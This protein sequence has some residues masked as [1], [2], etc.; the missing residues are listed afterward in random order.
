MKKLKDK[1]HILPDMER[2]I[3]VTGVNGFVGSNLL[4]RLMMERRFHLVALDIKK[5]DFLKKEAVKFYKIDLTQPNVD[6][7]ILSVVKREAVDTFIHL[8]FLSSPAP[9]TAYAHEM[10]VIGTMSVLHA[11]AEG[12]VRKLIVGSTTMVYGA[13]PMNPNFLDENAP[14]NGAGGYH[15]VRDKVEV[16]QL[17]GKFRKRYPDRIV[18]VLRPC[19]IVGP[20]VQNYATRLLRL[21]VVTTVLGY[22]PLFQF[23]HEEDV[24]DAFLLAV[25][26]D[27]SGEY[28]VVGRGV[29]PISTL[30]KL[31][32]KIAV[33]VAHFVAA[34]I[35]DVLW[36]ANLSPIP[37]AHLNY[38]RYL[39]VVDGEKAKKELGF[40]PRYSTKEA[41][42]NFVGTQ[43]LKDLHLLK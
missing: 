29:L 4:S 3:A 18:T 36:G 42:E 11:C 39:W 20:T 26:K 40:T 35:L 38:L 19:T 9:T 14:L 6:E 34:P 15:F 41:L 31:A 32:G 23:I 37:G 30:L 28:N 17:V 43:R 27:C 25:R 1:A 2:R 33:P 24:I 7:T 22:D 13:H 16:E 10:E 8:A 21:P 5:P 12:K